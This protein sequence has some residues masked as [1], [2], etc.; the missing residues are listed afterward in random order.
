[1]SQLS[2]FFPQ[3][4]CKVVF[5]PSVRLAHFFPF[6]DRLPN[7]LRSGVVYKFQC[8]NCNVSYYGQTGRH[9]NVRISEHIGVSH[10]TGNILADPVGSTVFNHLKSCMFVHVMKCKCGRNLEDFSVLTSG[11]SEFQ[12]KIKESLLIS[13]DKPTLNKAVSSLPLRLF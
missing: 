7:C 13:K 8:G 12:L 5:K 6:K 11:A 10:L 1:M 3:V 9:L 2:Q 4:E